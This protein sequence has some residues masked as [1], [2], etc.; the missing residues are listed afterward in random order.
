MYNRSYIELTLTLYISNQNEEIAMTM[1][2]NNPANLKKAITLYKG[3]P[4]EN[5]ESELLGNTRVYVDN[6]N[7][8]VPV[9]SS[10]TEYLGIFPGYGKK[11]LFSGQLEK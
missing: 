2:F 4:A 1:T 5:I 11:F 9:A 7:P 10:T 8:G 3:V 6:R